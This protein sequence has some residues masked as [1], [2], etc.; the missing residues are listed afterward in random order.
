MNRVPDV[1]ERR[2]KPVLPAAAAEVRCCSPSFF[3]L[4]PKY[5]GMYLIYSFRSSFGGT[6]TC[7]K[8]LLR[9]KSKDL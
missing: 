8:M 9:V 1:G 7:S 2:V 3:K 6:I 5:K 4:S